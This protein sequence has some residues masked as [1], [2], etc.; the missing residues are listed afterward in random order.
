MVHFGKRQVYHGGEGMLRF[1]FTIVT[2]PLSMALISS[3]C[4]LSNALVPSA[5]NINLDS[6][7]QTIYHSVQI[8]Q[9]LDEKSKLASFFFLS[10]SI[11]PFNEPRA[12]RNLQGN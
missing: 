6:S 10:F 4:I 2:F 7:Y 9:Q 8:Q 5:E 12:A 11:H 1:L 3:G